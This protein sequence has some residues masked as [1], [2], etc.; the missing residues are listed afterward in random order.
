MSVIKTALSELKR[1]EKAIIDSFSDDELSLKLFEMGCIPG[2]QVE[3][4]RIAPMGDPVA[5]SIA[6][7]VLSLRKDEAITVNVSRLTP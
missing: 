3:M 5:V 1:G 2:E 6:G 4:L 7:Y